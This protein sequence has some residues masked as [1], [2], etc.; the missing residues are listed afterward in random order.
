M[1]GYQIGVVGAGSCDEDALGFAKK[2]HRVLLLDVDPTMLGKESLLFQSV[3][4][5]DVK[6]GRISEEGKASVFRSVQFVQDLKKLADSDIVIEAVSE[7]MDLKKS[8]FRWF[9]NVPARCLA[10]TNTSSLSI[11]E[12]AGGLETQAFW[13]CTFSIRLLSCRWWKWSGQNRAKSRRSL[14]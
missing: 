14:L 4:S 7:R 12:I 2:G 1:T 11:T 3:L 8:I 9:I 10:L 13:G 6:K 5:R